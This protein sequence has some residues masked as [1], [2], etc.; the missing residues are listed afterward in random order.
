MLR[1]MT[2]LRHARTLS[3]L[4]ALATPGLALAEGIE[5]SGTAAMGLAGGSH[6]ERGSRVALMSDLELQLRISRTTDSGLTI[7]VE[8]TL[9]DLEADAPPYGPFGPSRR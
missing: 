4:A 7:G 9:D 6:P 3:C 2:L 5:I 8:Y 1:A